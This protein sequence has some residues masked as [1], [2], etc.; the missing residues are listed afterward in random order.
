MKDYRTRR[1]CDKTL[2]MVYY[3]HTDYNVP[4]SL[5]LDSKEIEQLVQENRHLSVYVGI[6]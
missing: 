3:L 5:G 4:L 1:T 2:Y 6:S